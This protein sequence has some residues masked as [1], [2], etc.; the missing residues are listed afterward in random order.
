MGKGD[1]IDIRSDRWLASGDMIYLNENSDLKWVKELIDPVCKSWNLSKLRQEFLPQEAIKILQT[2]IA[3][4]FNEE[5]IWWPFSKS[6]DFTVKSAYYLSK[7]L[8]QRVSTAASSST[9]IDGSLWKNIWV[10][11]IPQKIKYFLW[12]VCLNILRVGENLSKKRIKISTICPLCEVEV[13]TAEHVLMFCE[14][15]RVVWFGVQI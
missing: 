2:P 9:P 7:K 11:S 13:E 1:K 12:K 4:N 6:G 3:W 5:K 10:V 8:N 14:W 15:T